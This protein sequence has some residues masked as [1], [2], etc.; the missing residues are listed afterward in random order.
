MTDSPGVEIA[1][2]LI[3]SELADESARRP[4]RVALAADGEW[5]ARPMTVR[6][7]AGRQ[8]RMRFTRPQLAPA[9]TA[10]PA[11]RF[12]RVP[13]RF[14]ICQ[15]EIASVIA[16]A[17][18]ELTVD[19]NLQLDASLAVVAKLGP[20]TVDASG[21]GPQVF[22]WPTRAGRARRAP[23]LRRIGIAAVPPPAL[24]VA[25]RLTTSK[26]S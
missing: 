2:R 17:G 15:R 24:E 20:P 11:G 21:I 22:A 14:G 7:M 1:R 18:H 9:A 25:P 26:I 8:M 6:I 4:G 23:R 12:E 16:S 13:K 19:E 3:E 5:F 10:R